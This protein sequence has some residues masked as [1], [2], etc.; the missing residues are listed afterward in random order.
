MQ[1]LAARMAAVCPPHCLI[2]LSGTLGAGKTT[3][4]RGFLRQLGHAGAVKSPT[5]TLIEPY[6]LPAHRVYHFDLYRLNDP[7][8][9]EAIGIRDYFS[10]QAISLVEW[11]ERGHG[12]LPPV[13]VEIHIEIHGDCRVLGLSPGTPRGEM[14]LATL[15]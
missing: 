4:V 1:A 7:E 13:D 15:E 6:Q 12:F 8:E 10:E 5:Y 9:L 14:I 3:F 11:P 2:C